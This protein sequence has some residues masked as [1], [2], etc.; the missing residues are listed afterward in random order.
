MKIQGEVPD[1]GSFINQHSIM[2][3]P[4]LSGSGMR[5]KILEGMALGKVVLTTSV[6]LEGIEARHKKEVLVAD[7]S[8]EFLDALNF[9]QELSSGQLQQIGSA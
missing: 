6:G 7:T 4:L 5:A 8:K 3:V 1:A 2:V 9:C